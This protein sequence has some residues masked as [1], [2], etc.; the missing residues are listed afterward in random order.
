MLCSVSTGAGVSIHACGE[1]V[2]FTT[3][4]VPWRAFGEPSRLEAGLR[5]FVEVAHK[6]GA[7]D[8]RRFRRI[9]RISVSAAPAELRL[10]LEGDSS[11][12]PCS[13]VGVLLMIVRAIGD[14]QLRGL[15]Y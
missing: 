1:D 12:R 14:E 15:A 2:R 6:D 7:G 10:S 3:W 5:L 11:A 9:R 13:K 8:A 4:P